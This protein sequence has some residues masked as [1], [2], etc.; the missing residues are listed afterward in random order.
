[1][2]ETLVEIIWIIWFD[3]FNTLEGDVM[4]KIYNYNRKEP[5]DSSE[6]LIKFRKLKIINT[7]WLITPN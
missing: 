5:I 2:N 7:S 1:M 3:T 6:T 4:L